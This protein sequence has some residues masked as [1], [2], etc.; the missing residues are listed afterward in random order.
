MNRQLIATLFKVFKI[1]V[2]CCALWF[3]TVPPAF[4]GS[5]DDYFVAVKNDDSKVVT[6]LLFRGF[7]PNTL[8][9]NGV[10][11]LLIAA[12]EGSLKVAALLL[13]QNKTQVEV[14]SAQ[15]ESAL[16]MAAL[17]GY[18][19]LAKN[20]IERGADVNKTGWT[21]LHYAA[22]KGHLA[23]MKLLLEHHAYID[24]E[25]PNKTT[26]LMMAAMYG[27]LDAVKLL[28]E[29]GADLG[30]KNEQDLTAF[31]FAKRA[32]REDSAA[33]LHKSAPR[34]KGAW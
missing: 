8:D 23:I 19:S 31:D 15:D 33:L 11:G 2:S 29:A 4:A 24:A 5:Y 6:N 26:P 13:S 12:R 21:P 18:E 30:L 14:R 7:D 25:S 1:Y 17:G 34:V 3:G 22:T 9:P 32:N 10:H 28:I 20:L 27:T 16:M